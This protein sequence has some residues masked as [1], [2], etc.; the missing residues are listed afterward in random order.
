MLRNPTGIQLSIELQI[1]L[2]QRG[3]LTS[4]ICLSFFSTRSRKREQHIIQLQKVVGFPRENRL[5]SIRTGRMS[6][7]LGRKGAIPATLSYFTI[8]CKTTV[9]PRLFYESSRLVT[10]SKTLKAFK[11]QKSSI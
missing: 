2:A 4:T 7:I 10:A 5:G 1:S 11:T 9:A 6:D 3:R 8:V